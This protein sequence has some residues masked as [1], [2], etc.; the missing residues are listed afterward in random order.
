MRDERRESYDEI[1]QSLREG[2]KQTH[3]RLQAIEDELK[4]I[5]EF[6][7]K[8]DAAKLASIGILGVITAI[9]ATVSWF[10]SVRDHVVIHKP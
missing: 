4:P 7:Q 8:V 1:L 9:G 6:M 2:Q 10:L 5:R 3:D